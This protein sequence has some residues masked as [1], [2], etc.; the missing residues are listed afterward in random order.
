[1]HSEV[2]WNLICLQELM[3]NHACSHEYYHYTSFVKAAHIYDS[4]MDKD[5]F[6]QGL[7]TEIAEGSNVSG[8]EK[9]VCISYCKKWSIGK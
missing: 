5:K 6:P 3:L 7:R 1:M 8:G 2:R 4:I 9:Q